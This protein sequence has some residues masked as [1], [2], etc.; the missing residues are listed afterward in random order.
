[1][2]PLFEKYRPASW[3]DVVAQDKAI[4]QIQT[5]GTK[6]GYA[7]RAWWI[8]GQS[9][10]GK[11][12]LAY[13]LAKEV[14]DETMIE[15]LD[16]AELTPARL[17]EIE[18]TMSSYGWGKGGRAYIVNEA[19]G[20]SKP[21]VRQLLVLLERLPKHVVVIFTTTNDGEDYLFEGTDDAGPL[22]SR[23]IKIT[24]SRRDL[25]QAFAI[26][27]K[28]IAEQEGLDGQPVEKYVKLVQACRN[29]MRAVLCEIE[30]GVMVS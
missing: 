19:H 17:R 30:K 22:L 18:S 28:A 14:A 4:Q 26:R 15:E 10:T 25:A 7:S 29:N 24:L 23:C 8:A 9:G 1:M 27:A 13:L 20:L 6:S 2:K 12:T 21:S 11:T 3:C 5:I 16:A